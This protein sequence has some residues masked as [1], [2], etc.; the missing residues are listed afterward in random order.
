ML[1]AD[2][3]LMMRC[4]SL[5][6]WSLKSWQKVCHREKKYSGVTSFS[7]GFGFT[8]KNSTVSLNLKDSKTNHSH[9]TPVHDMRLTLLKKNST[10]SLNLKDSKTNHSHD[11]PTHE[12]NTS[13]ISVKLRDSKASHPHDANTHMISKL[14]V[15]KSTVSL[16][17]KD[18]ASQTVPVTLQHTI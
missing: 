16:N 10:V 9:D 14:H 17:L 2:L 6:Q 11:T 18:T 13:H 12:I 3:S 15:V 4:C 1:Y 7:P 5:F 8:K